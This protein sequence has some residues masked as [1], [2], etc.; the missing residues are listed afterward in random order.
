MALR[1]IAKECNIAIGTIY[2]YFSSKDILV[3]FVMLEDWEKYLKK[4]KMN[5]ESTN[6]F[7]EGFSYIY[8]GIIEFSNIY[9]KI[10]GEYSFTGNTKYSFSEGHKII[11][12]QITD[13]V[14]ILLLRFDKQ[15]DDG[16]CGFLAESLL[17]VAM[18]EDMEFELLTRVITKLFD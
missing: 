10:W 6:D 14:R 16:I 7:V 18:Q 9:N 13:I 5:C 12:N 4:M 17:T 1:S 3:A 15:W 11:R 8:K 2:N